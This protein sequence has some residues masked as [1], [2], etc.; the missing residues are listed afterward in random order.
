MGWLSNIFTRINPQKVF[1]TVAS[2]ADKLIF[3]KEEKAELNKEMIQAQAEFVK[4]TLNESSIRSYTRRVIA[5]S[6]VSVY[7]FLVLLGVGFYPFIPAYSAF[8]FSVVSELNMAFIATIS[9]YFGCSMLNI[10]K[11]GKKK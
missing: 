7:L 1:D 10:H 4:N 3:T 2:G 6:I 8:I 9:F 11:G 5:V